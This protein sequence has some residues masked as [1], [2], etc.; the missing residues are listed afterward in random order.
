MPEELI[1]GDLNIDSD[2]VSSV[3]GPPHSYDRLQRRPCDHLGKPFSQESRNLLM[4]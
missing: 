1:H 2:G 4:E 3:L